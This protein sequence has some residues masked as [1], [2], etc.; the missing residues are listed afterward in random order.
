MD[1]DGP[2]AQQ[3]LTDMRESRIHLAE[4]NARY[5][6]ALAAAS[7]AQFSADGATGLR[8]A[9]HDYGEMLNRYAAAVNAWAEF[10]LKH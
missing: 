9:A 7:D 1:L 6:K 2:A 10:V 4:A 5:Q 3:L 8:I